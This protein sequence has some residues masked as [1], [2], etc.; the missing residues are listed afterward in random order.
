M[1]DSRARRALARAAAHL[2]AGR[3]VP[4]LPPLILMTDDKRLAD[5]LGAASV[6]PKGSAVILRSRQ[7]MEQAARA[8][9]IIARRRDLIVL[10]AGDP[11]LADRIGADG[12]HLP[13]ARA[14]QAFGW[15]A[16]RPRWLITTSAHSLDAAARAFQW[17]ASAVLL[18]PVFATSS[19][20]DRVPLSPVRARAIAQNVPGPIYALGGI[21]A[22]NALSLSGSAFVGLAAIGALSV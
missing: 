14:R 9:M 2:A 4:P 1:S 13:E 18:S 12:L 7:P 3:R 8:L 11:E 19:H 21:G 22:Q 16:R 10:V 5:P 6:L 17:K 20:P 15:A